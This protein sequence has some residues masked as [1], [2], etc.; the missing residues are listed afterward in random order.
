MYVEFI[1]VTRHTLPHNHPLS[2]LPPSFLFPL[3]HF[4]FYFFSFL[5]LHHLLIPF[6]FFI[7]LFLASLF[8]FSS[9]VSIL[10]PIS[11]F[12]LFPFFFLSFLHSLFVFLPILSF[13][14]TLLTSFLSL[15]VPFFSSF[16]FCPRL[17]SSLS[18][19]SSRFRTFF[20]LP[21]RRFLLL[22]QRCFSS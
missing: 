12:L 7:F 18:P 17:C 22:F 20:L 14:F 16:S 5:S 1:Q 10:C 11:L 19:I 4:P 2:T 3:F 13:S 6:N 15:F 8:T 21:F 9:P